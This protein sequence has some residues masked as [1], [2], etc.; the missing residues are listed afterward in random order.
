MPKQYKKDLTSVINTI[1]NY[2]LTLKTSAT[3]EKVLASRFYIK[4]N[5]FAT[6]VDLLKNIYQL[7]N[8]DYN[9]TYATLKNCL[10]TCARASL[11]KCK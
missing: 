11:V 5:D 8:T 10:I 9:I 6:L 4:Q 7:H 2:N 3:S 1:I